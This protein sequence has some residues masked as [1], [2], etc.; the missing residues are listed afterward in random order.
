[1]T[2]LQIT[3][4]HISILAQFFLPPLSSQGRLLLRQNTCDALSTL[5]TRD[6]TVLRYP[7]V[8]PS[9]VIAAV[10][11]SGKYE[12]ETRIGRRSSDMYIR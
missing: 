8:L 4:D 6:I 11:D 10:E 9:F 2:H 5:V 1:M 3:P 12:Q 7:E